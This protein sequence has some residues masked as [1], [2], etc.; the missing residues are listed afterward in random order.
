MNKSLLML[1]G[2]MMV[3]SA[4]AASIVTNKISSIA[5]PGGEQQVYLC[6]NPVD[7]TVSHEVGNIE[8]GASFSLPPAKFS[9]FNVRLQGCDY[10]NAYLGNMT[11]SHY[12][13][14]GE[15]SVA[16][17]SPSDTANVEGL[18]INDG[19]LSGK[20]RFIPKPLPKDGLP[21]VSHINDDKS[22]WPYVGINLSGNEFGKM[23]NP[24]TSP[25]ADD[26]VPFIKAGMNTF[27]LPIR[28]S[29]LQPQGAGVGDFNETYLSFI[30]TFLT[31]ATQNKVHVI[32]DVH[33]YMRYSS[34]GAYAGV[35]PGGSSPDGQIV[36][37]QAFVAL[38]SQLFSALAK[39]QNID[40]HYLMFDLS[41][42][43]TQMSSVGGTE[44]VLQYQNAIIASLRKL[45]AKNLILVEGNE[46]TGL[47][48]WTQTAGDGS[49][50]NSKVFTRQAIQDPLNNIAINVHQYFDSNF[51]GTSDSC[52]ANL[53][54]INM[55][56][57][58]NYLKENKLKAIVT[59]F[60]TGRGEH[61]SQ[62]LDGFLKLLKTHAYTKEKDYGFIGW[63][64]WSGGHGWGG[65]PA[66]TLH[67][68]EQAPQMKVLSNYLHGKP[69]EMA[70]TSVNF[71]VDQ[72]STIGDGCSLQIH[73]KDWSQKKEIVTGLKTTTSI[74]IE[75][76]FNDGTYLSVYCA[77]D[78]WQGHDAKNSL[79]EAKNDVVYSEVLKW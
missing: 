43:P 11:I 42:E 39:D 53:D 45:G 79:I 7:D 69:L 74:P 67:V 65:Y 31:Q 36:T 2:L 16:A 9:N 5:M 70:K 26:M 58:V 77:I 55:D 52:R 28:W 8:P 29:Y 46:W 68:D 71:I 37:E 72:P 44:T 73:N 66:Y 61:C 54:A 59:E 12:A 47:H 18:S 40:Q 14:T 10:N 32:L 24:W 27:R 56:D 17:Y 3:T 64:I 78:N 50:A 49:T 51:S 41:N 30:K 15:L 35:P 48:S 33:N 76:L 13:P 22:P 57:F 6:N 60:G 20:P 25:N 1:T 19:V 75:S 38:W 63:T 23:W 4:Q 62:A 34:P 21:A